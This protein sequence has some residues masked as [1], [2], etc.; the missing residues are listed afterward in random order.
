MAK[1]KI[2]IELFQVFSENPKGCNLETIQGSHRYIANVI[3]G[4][5]ESPNKSVLIDIFNSFSKDKIKDYVYNRMKKS[6]LLELALCILQEIAAGGPDRAINLQLQIDKT[7]SGG[8]QIIIAPDEG[9]KDEFPLSHSDESTFL[10][11][12]EASFSMLDA[13]GKS[14]EK[15]VVS[16]HGKKCPYS[17]PDEHGYF[18]PVKGQD[19]NAWEAPEIPQASPAKKPAEASCPNGSATMPE[20]AR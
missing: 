6:I 20:V 11:I 7:S 15:T 12:D 8:K 19:E 17:Q 16:G 1:E 2:D 14:P 13:H 5:E 10:E 9:K 18:T 3:K 4:S